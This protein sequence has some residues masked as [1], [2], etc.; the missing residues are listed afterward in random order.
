MKNYIPLHAGLTRRHFMRVATTMGV[1]IC[2]GLLSMRMSARAQE[3]QPAGEP[4]M[5]GDVLLLPFVLDRKFEL[6]G[7]GMI[8]IKFPIGASESTV[9]LGAVRA[10][11]QP[12]ENAAAE[13]MIEIMAAV[14]Q[15]TAYTPHFNVEL[16]GADGN[17]IHKMEYT[18]REI[19]P[20]VSGGALQRSFSPHVVQ[21]GATDHANVVQIAIK[22]W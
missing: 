10:Y 16:L 3:P 12:R 6:R 20:F 8:G 2:G 17:P 19:T 21:F 14:L 4:Q 15:K 9:E 18:G 11:L 5:Q 22:A 7:P 1:G 13:L